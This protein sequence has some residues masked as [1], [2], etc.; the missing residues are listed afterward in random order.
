[1]RVTLISPYADVHAFGIRTLSACLKRE[2]ACDVQLMFLPRLFTGKYKDST[3]NEIVALA[4]KADLIGISLMTN[5]FDNAVQISRSV[6]ENLSVPVVWGGIHPTV[7]PAECLDYADVACIGEGEATLVE[8][9]RNIRDGQ[10]FRNVP[11]ICFKDKEEIVTNK[12]RPL[13]RDLDSIPFPDYDYETHYMLS[14]GCIRTIDTDLLKKEI[15]VIYLT[16]PTRG[17]PFGC[18]YCCNNKLNKMYPKPI[19]K[20]SVDNVIKELMAA[21]SRLPFIERIRFASDSFFVY[22]TEEI[23]DFARKYK[24]NVGLPLQITGVTANLS[25]EKLSPLVDAGLDSTRMGIQTGAE[26][27]KRLYKRYHSNQQ[28]EKTVRLINEFNDKIRLPGYDV[29]LDNP[30][31]TEDDSIETLMFLS[32][33]PTPYKLFLFSLTFF[34]GTELYELAKKD[35]IVKDDLR[36]I[37]RKDYVCC[38]NTY[39]NRLFFLLD[40]HAQRGGRIS[41]KMMSLLTNRRLRQ[42]KLSWLLYII[43]KNRYIHLTIPFRIK[44]LLRE[45]CKDIRKG[46]WARI[47][48]YMK[49]SHNL[50]VRRKFGRQ[51][52]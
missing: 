24:E 37:Y 45:G 40:E 13:I 41:P 11:G 51:V 9:A 12:L 42:L 26:H 22:T 52:K 33:L 34:P 48:R 50:V 35:G 20:R 2:K 44:Y 25:R 19:R 23:T 29:I 28:V 30:W 31:E 1:M 7:R 32:R 6:K 3:L 21:K 49:R 38:K 5:F 46:N 36:D 17:C 18:A 27:T 4:E 43:L 16:L 14:D 47:S 39:L 8:L 15:G 10:D